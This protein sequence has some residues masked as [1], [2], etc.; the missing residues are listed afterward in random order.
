[1]IN[2][3]L[4]SPDPE[5]WKINRWKGSIFNWENYHRYP[6]NEVYLNLTDPVTGAPL[7]NADGI[8]RRAI[9]DSCTPGQEIVSRKRTQLGLVNESTAREYINQ[10]VRL[11]GPNN[12]GIAIA[13]VPTT[14]AQLGG[15]P[16]AIG[17]P[18]KGH[19]ILEVPVQHQPVPESILRYADERDAL[20]RD[21]DGKVYELPDGLP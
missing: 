12:P 17:K 9:L 16:N 3:E 18:L 8:P 20:I 10:A 21:I 13:D 5:Y 19:L 1:M 6:A 11:Y 4:A 15:I 14:R 7:L 2:D